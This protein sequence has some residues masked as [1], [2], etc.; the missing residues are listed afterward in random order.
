MSVKNSFFMFFSFF[1]VV[2]ADPKVSDH[3][4]ISKN[5]S[6]S[7]TIITTYEP[8][9]L[10]Y[11]SLN[12]ANTSVSLDLTGHIDPEV[13]IER[14]DGETVLDIFKNDEARFRVTCND[15]RKVTVTFNTKN[16]WKLLSADG[17]SICYEVNFKGNNRTEVVKEKNNTVDIDNNEFVNSEYE[18]S[19]SFKSVEKNLKAGEYFD[20]ITI[21]VST[22]C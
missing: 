20:R 9:F 22:A 4:D 1:G 10:A 3:R 18:F 13:N 14:I 6:F 2:C 8:N 17:N 11:T 12:S 16:N 15:D 7:P 21:S 5:T 19:V